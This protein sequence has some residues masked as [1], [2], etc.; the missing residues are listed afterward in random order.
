MNRDEMEGKAENLKGRVKEAAGVITGN[1]NLENEGAAQ[2]TDGAVQEGLGAA[3]RKVGE[4]LEDLG[5]NVK[6]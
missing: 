2:R 6:R 5:K 3:R 4:A 1:P